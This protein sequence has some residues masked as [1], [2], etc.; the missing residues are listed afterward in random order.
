MSWDDP[1]R[2]GLREPPFA[3]S[4]VEIINGVPNLNRMR[5]AIWEGQRDSALIRNAEVAAGIHG[6]SGEDK[7]TYLAYHALVMAEKQHK[8]LCNL[9]NLLPTPPV[10]L[11]EKS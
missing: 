4:M 6:F 2:V 7:Y 1:I 11:K 9:W 10:I 3:E 5:K 8:E